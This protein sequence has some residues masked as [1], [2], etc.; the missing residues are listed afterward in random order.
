[1]PAFSISARMSARKGSPATPGS[2]TTSTRLMP[3]ALTR[4][5]SSVMRPAPARISV[6]IRQLPRNSIILH[7]LEGAEAL[8][9]RD[10]RVKRVQ[11][12]FRHIGIM[13]HHIGTEGGMGELALAEELRRVRQRMGHARQIGGIGI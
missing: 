9:V 1:M 12:N 4:S 8:P 3:R 5:G 10:G 6:G 7:P 2:V 11:L 13:L